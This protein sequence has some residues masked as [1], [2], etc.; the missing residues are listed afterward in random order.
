[1]TNTQLDNLLRNR[2][3]ER[4]SNL[5]A[6]E[7]DT[8]ILRISNNEIAIP[9]VDDEN[10]EKFVTIKVSVPRGTRNHKGGY[11]EYDAYALAEDYATTLEAKQKKKEEKKND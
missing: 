8:E 10:N 3:M 4:I 9:A 6:N 5:I 2:F 1:M 7:F 11:D